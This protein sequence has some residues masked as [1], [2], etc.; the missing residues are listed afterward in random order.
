MYYLILTVFELKKKWKVQNYMALCSTKYGFS[1]RNQKE[2]WRGKVR[3]SFFL[4]KKA[5]KSRNFSR[6]KIQKS[7][8]DKDSS[9]LGNKVF[10]EHNGI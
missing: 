7:F 9:S 6:I 10:N 8:K 4:G 3:L 1:F 2:R 5:E